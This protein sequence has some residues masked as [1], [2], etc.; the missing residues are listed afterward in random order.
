M[1]VVLPSLWR[2]H[3]ESEC[4]DKRITDFR[5]CSSPF[6]RFDNEHLARERWEEMSAAFAGAVRLALCCPLLGFLESIAVTGE[7]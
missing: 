6:P 4:A 2:P 3:G 1:D 7:G 5:L